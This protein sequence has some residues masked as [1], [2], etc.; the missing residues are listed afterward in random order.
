M[1]PFEYLHGWAKAMQT[2]WGG[3]LTILTHQDMAEEELYEALFSDTVDGLPAAETAWLMQFGIGGKSSMRVY[4]FIILI[5]RH[6][7]GYG[8]QLG[9]DVYVL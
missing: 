7:G 8:E 9:C 1:G 4:R 3:L 5:F 2:A 6:V